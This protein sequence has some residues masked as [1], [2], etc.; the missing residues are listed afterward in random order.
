MQ[1][2]HKDAEKAL[3]TLGFEK[4][5]KSKSTSHSQWRKHFPGQ[6][7]AMR[8]VTLDKHNS[9]Y[10]KWLLASIIKQSGVTKKEFLKAAGLR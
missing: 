1:V 10:C 9:P 2:S 5:E 7:P 8:K 4:D 3:K 6:N